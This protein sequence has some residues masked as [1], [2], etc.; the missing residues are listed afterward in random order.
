MRLTAWPRKLFGGDRG[1]GLLVLG[2]LY[3]TITW[4]RCP[5]VDDRNRLQRLHR[6]ANHARAPVQF[7]VE[8][9]LNHVEVLTGPSAARGLSEGLGRGV[10]FHPAVAGQWEADEGAVTGELAPGLLD[11]EI[12]GQSVPNV[13]W[14]AWAAKA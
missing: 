1:R 7:E 14:K 3:S 5:R 2:E 9:S 6:G 13:L 4:V 8:E 10:R 11:G 12:G